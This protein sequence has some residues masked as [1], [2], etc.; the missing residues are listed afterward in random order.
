MCDRQTGPRLGVIGGQP[1]RGTFDKGEQ[2][3]LRGSLQ[4]GEGALAGNLTERAARGV[5]LA[6]A[7]RLGGTERAVLRSAEAVLE[8]SL[9]AMGLRGVDNRRRW[10][11]DF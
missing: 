10:Q 8:R 4:Q 3:R 5:A 2:A 1:S 11:Q 6:F 7:G 9:R